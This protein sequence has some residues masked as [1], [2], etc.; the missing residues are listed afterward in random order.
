MYLPFA[1]GQFLNQLYCIE[2]MLLDTLFICVFCRSSMSYGNSLMS[3]AW[4]LFLDVRHIIACAN[5]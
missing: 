5:L 4:V 1:C 3:G 2:I